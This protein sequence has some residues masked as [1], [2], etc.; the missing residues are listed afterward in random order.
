MVVFHE[1]NKNY[2]NFNRI[3]IFKKIILVK[4]YYQWYFNVSNSVLIYYI[5]QSNFKKCFIDLPPRKL[6][7]KWLEWVT[8]TFEKSGGF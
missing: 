5:I 1:S 6:N 4:V 7:S 3:K 8:N 2:I